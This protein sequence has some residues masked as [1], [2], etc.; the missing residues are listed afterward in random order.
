MIKGEDFSKPKCRRSFAAIC[1]ESLSPMLSVGREIN[2]AR[3]RFICRECSWEGG[4]SEL[5]TGL[6]RISR[7]EMY[8]YSYRCP[9]CGSYDVASQG[10][11]L[12]FVSRFGST[13]IEPTRRS[14]DEEV[15]PHATVENTNRSWE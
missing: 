1:K 13:S 5:K 8:L 7:T 6:V 2:I 9:A 3:R 11:L 4:G 14:V 10:K 12:A 15:Q